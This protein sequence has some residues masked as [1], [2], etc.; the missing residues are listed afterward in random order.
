MPLEPP[1]KDRVQNTL[2]QHHIQVKTVILGFREP[3]S[4][5][6]NTL[7]FNK[8]KEIFGLD[9]HGMAFEKMNSEKPVSLIVLII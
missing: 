8:Y 7:R 2:A 4:L 1:L 3:F 9:Q 5:I 6:Y